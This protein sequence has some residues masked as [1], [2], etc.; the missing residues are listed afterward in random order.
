MLL[1]PTAVVVGADTARMA[2]LNTKHPLTRQPSCADCADTAL[3]QPDS[4]PQRCDVTVPNGATPPGEQ[5]STQHHGN[6]ALWTSLSPDGELRLGVGLPG[7]VTDHGEMTIKLPWWRGKIGRL[8]VTGRRL[9]HLSPDLRV[10]IPNGYGETGFQSTALTF[11][12]EGCWQV[13]GQLGNSRLTFVVS[14]VRVH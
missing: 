8:R 1:L 13:S 5:R 12:S 14:V 2:D 9:D 4:Q 10:R 6:G 7:E 3:A 11:P